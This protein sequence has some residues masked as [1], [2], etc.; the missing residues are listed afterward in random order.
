MIAAG[1]FPRGSALF[2]DGSDRLIAGQ[3]FG[4]GIAM[5]LD[6]GIDTRRNDRSNRRFGRRQRVEDLALVIGPI[7]AE[8]FDGCLD[9]LSN[10]STCEAS[11]A[12][13]VVSVCATIWPVASST[14]RV[15][16]APRAPR[17]RSVLPHRPLA[18]AIHFQPRRVDD[19]VDGGRVGAAA[20]VRPPSRRAAARGWS[21][22]VPGGQAPAAPTP[23]RQSPRLGAGANDRSSAASAPFGWRRPKRYIGPPRFVGPW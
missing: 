16:R 12:W 21:S 8:G 18:L 9:L 15:E 5:L 1:F 7:A 6:F 20:G 19:Q 23:N 13:A 22:P 10:G 4:F 2:S 14:P 17:A 11:S 3:G